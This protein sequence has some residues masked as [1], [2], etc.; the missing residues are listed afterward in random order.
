MKRRRAMTLRD[1]GELF[2]LLDE[3]RQAEHRQGRS[4]NRAQLIRE[5][6][7]ASLRMLRRPRLRG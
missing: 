1:D 7:H 3:R 2:D 5:I 6:L 4:L